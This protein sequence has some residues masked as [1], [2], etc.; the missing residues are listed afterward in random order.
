VTGRPTPSLS[1]RLTTVT[2]FAA[3][4]AVAF[5]VP[6]DLASAGEEPGQTPEAKRI[7]AAAPALQ[8][9]LFVSIRDNRLPGISPTW[10]SFSVDIDAPQSVAG[11]EWS[12][13]A[14][15]GTP[16]FLDDETV[17]ILSKRPQNEPALWKIGLSDC[18][19]QCLVALDQP[20]D[21]QREYDEFSLHRVNGQIVAELVRMR[22]GR[23]RST[24][25]EGEASILEI[26][27]R[28]GRVDVKKAQARE[29]P[30]KQN[31]QEKLLAGRRTADTLLELPPQEETRGKMEK[32][33]A[34]KGI[35]FDDTRARFQVS[36]NMIAGLSR[37]VGRLRLAGNGAADALGA[38]QD[39]LQELPTAPALRDLGWQVRLAAA[40]I[41]DDV[42]ELDQ[43]L[44][45]AGIKDDVPRE[46]AV[47]LRNLAAYQRL[48]LVLENGDSLADY[49]AFVAN[50]DSTVAARDAAILRMHEIGFHAACQMATVNAFDEFIRWAPDSL[51]F[52]KALEY[53]DSLE[54]ERIASE[55]ANAVDARGRREELAAEQYTIWLAS[56]RANHI[57]KAKRCFGLL[58]EHPD[59]KRTQAAMRAQDTQD[60]RE[61]RAIVIRQ[62]E[63]QT[64]VL[65][66]VA[67]VQRHQ[68][69]VMG[70]QLAEQK[71]TNSQ[72]REIR[73]NQQ[74]Q[75]AEQQR[76]NS[77]LDMANSQLSI[78]NSQLNAVRGQ[79]NIIGEASTNA[80]M[81][82]GETSRVLRDIK[83]QLE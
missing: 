71:V 25:F 47:A 23:R 42:R 44:D 11:T 16:V 58:S 63:E 20:P 69:D 48:R 2:H 67:T 81:Q 66:T 28:T 30:S 45:G 49:Q 83:R 57:E 73:S 34:K 78:A 21:G 51:Q 40:V 82:S 38:L 4:A 53:A 19:I 70:R 18:S 43:L 24:S 5:A 65:K 76:S 79:L 13:V 8:S 1:H 22:V 32:V 29:R 14:G 75:L 33:L 7:R 72:L 62:N 77:L 80:A 55:L 9:P 39:K 50:C 3:F 56:L 37:D 12:G 46:R 17:A 60:L 36:A 61:F 27:L 31:L 74:A 41:A 64:E 15:Y 26:D 35:A 59:L 52:E 68:L 54:R 10:E 6:A